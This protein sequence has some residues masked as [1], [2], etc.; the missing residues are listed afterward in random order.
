LAKARLTQ[1]QELIDAT[2]THFDDVQ[3][4][5]DDA[6][7]TCDDLKSSDAAVAILTERAALTL[8]TERVQLA[9]D[10][11]LKLQIGKDSP[12]WK[13]A[14][15]ALEQAHAAVAQAN[16]QLALLDAQIVKLSVA[17]P[18]DAIVSTLSI[19][20]GEVISM[21]SVAITLSKLESLTILV[22]VPE[23]QLGNIAIGQ[24]ATLTVDS[25]PDAVFSAE[26][27][28]IADQA[29]FTP[30]NVSTTE[31]R[32]TTV[33]EVKLKVNDPGGLLKPGMPADVVFLPAK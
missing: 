9:Q 5:V 3:A 18:V 14:N 13:A 30:R 7:K 12:R 22:F 21:G 8:Q 2:Q 10:A 15:T 24:M 16:A 31:G 32:K 23:D 1:N 17:A 11:L 27:T 33:F 25:F 19:Q 26:V 20:P 4:S 28:H 29:E 6:Q